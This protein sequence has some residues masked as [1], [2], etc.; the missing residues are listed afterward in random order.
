MSPPSSTARKLIDG[1]AEAIMVDSTNANGTE[2]KKLPT[3]LNYQVTAN[4]S[5]RTSATHQLPKTGT[6]KPTDASTS[7]MRTLALTAN[8]SGQLLDNS[9]K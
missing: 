1:H 7:L 6:R 4:S 9:F 3:T 2:E 8:A 5:K